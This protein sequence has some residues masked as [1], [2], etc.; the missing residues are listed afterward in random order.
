M[1]RGRPASSGVKGAKVTKPAPAASS[2]TRRGSGRIAAI[3]QV[4]D[5]EALSDKT[6]RLDTNKKSRTAGKGGKLALVTAG[7]ADDSIMTVDSDMADYAPAAEP[8]TA[9]V[10]KGRGRP[11]KAAKAAAAT[12]RMEDD[13]S[14]DLAVVEQPPKRGRPRVGSVQ[15]S[16]RR[17]R[18][19]VIPE[20]QQPGED[21]D[22][23]L[24]EGMAD[25]VAVEEF[26][27][28]N[29]PSATAASRRA[30]AAQVP[31]D[32]AAESDTALRRRLGE[33][34]LRCESLK[35]KYRD[36]REIG[37][38]EAERNFERLK[39]QG[40]D[41]ANGERRHHLCNLHFSKIQG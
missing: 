30:A 22:F 9:A 16:T 31:S 25:D 13:M 35:M 7:A 10:P 41:R 27:Q 2:S 3:R 21:V 28:P 14:D 33:A 32:S 26:V 11:P 4:A 34:T 29:R 38:K 37:V 39:K 1:P 18:D 20:T 23:D 24:D 17:P 40:E 15:P 36:L 12:E 6:N 5:R 8:A 19:M